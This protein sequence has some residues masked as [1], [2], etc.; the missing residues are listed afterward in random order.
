MRGSKFQNPGHEDRY[1]LSFAVFVNNYKIMDC[2]IYIT[3]QGLIRT[4]LRANS[5]CVV[6]V[7]VDEH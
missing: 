6:I 5:Q 3:V 2:Q 7:A 4:V 1:V